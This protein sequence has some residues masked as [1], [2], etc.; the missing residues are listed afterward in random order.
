M[1]VELAALIFSKIVAQVGGNENAP[2]PTLN[3]HP[4]FSMK[5]AWNS[6]ISSG[7]T[8]NAR[9]FLSLN[10]RTLS[11]P[12]KAHARGVYLH[13]L[14]ESDILAENARRFVT[15]SHQVY[16]LLVK[17]YNNGQCYSFEEVASLLNLSKRT[18]A[19]RLNLENHCYRDLQSKARIRLAK[20]LL[21]QP[22]NSIKLV[23]AKAGFANISAFCRAFKSHTT[24][25]PTEYRAQ[26][27]GE[28]AAK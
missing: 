15:T 24:Q 26:Q 17:G 8:H 22:C 21:K 27:A 3:K 10:D 28:L 14:N 1:F 2:K 6:G 20:S 9:A 16:L 5:S 23:S 19:R 25:S 11:T 18:L 7:R 12:N 13:A 4:R